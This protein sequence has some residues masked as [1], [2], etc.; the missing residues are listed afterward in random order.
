M[1]AAPCVVARGRAAPWAAAATLS[2]A[3]TTAGCSAAGSRRS[4]LG[5]PSRRTQTQP[6]G[7]C[8]TAERVGARHRGLG[9]RAA[10]AGQ[11]CGA[12]AAEAEAQIRRLV[13]TIEARL[14]GR[15]P[16]AAGASS[17]AA[18]ASYAG[19]A[20]ELDGRPGVLRG[21]RGGLAMLRH[22][23][24]R[25]RRPRV[26][27][28]CSRWRSARAATRPGSAGPLTARLQ[29]LPRLAM[30]QDRGRRPTLAAGGGPMG[31]ETASALPA[32]HFLQLSPSAAAGL[33][34]HTH[35]LRT[36]DEGSSA[37]P[38]LIERDWRGREER[39]VKI[40]L[41]TEI[42]FSACVWLM[43]HLGSRRMI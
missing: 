41:H 28:A 22:Q 42:F 43:D 30:S 14:P 1:G 8:A 32:R 35:L 23:R 5:C 9:S 33:L 6:A 2:S 18:R 34:Q 37:R 39:T 21:R 11:G 26:Q 19:G 4:T 12:L 40:R 24:R 31:R 15:A 10:T 27:R 3:S 36:G 29:Q 25:H 16:R 38:E 7:S 20:C 13:A 17:A